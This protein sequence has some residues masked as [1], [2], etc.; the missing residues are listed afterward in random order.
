MPCTEKAYFIPVIIIEETFVNPVVENGAVL[1]ADV[2][3]EQLT[4]IVFMALVEED[5]NGKVAEPGKGERVVLVDNRLL[6]DTCPEVEIVK[7]FKLKVYTAKE[8]N[9]KEETELVLNKGINSKDEQLSNIPCIFVT[10]AV[11][12]KGT[13]FKEMQSENMLDIPVTEAV[14]NKGTD[15]KD[16]QPENMLFMVITEAVLNKGTDFKE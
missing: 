2:T 14:L 13:D 8:L 1:G 5:V 16:K 6:I 12:N 4:L 15:F 11:L 7:L 3:P 9:P 10:E